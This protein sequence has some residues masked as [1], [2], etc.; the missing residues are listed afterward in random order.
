MPKDMQMTQKKQKGRERR[1][2]N[3]MIDVNKEI[4]II[5]LNMNDVDM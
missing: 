4:W 2:A 1:N 3:K 5:I